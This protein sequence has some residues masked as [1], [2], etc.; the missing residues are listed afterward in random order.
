MLDD[1]E[2]AIIK[3]WNENSHHRAGFVREVLS[4]Y[5]LRLIEGFI[6]ER[7]KLD[8]RF[9]TPDKTIRGQASGMTVEKE[10]KKR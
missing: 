10:V 3:A 6:S 1:E 4:R 8:S 5:D 7:K 2:N 9:N